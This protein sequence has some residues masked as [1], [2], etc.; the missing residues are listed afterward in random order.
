MAKDTRWTNDEWRLLQ[1][2]L[3]AV[4]GTTR[5]RL[6]ELTQVQWDQVVADTKRSRAD[7]DAALDTMLKRQE[8][9]G[10]RVPVQT[11]ERLFRESVP[12]LR[13]CLQA[14]LKRKVVNR[15]SQTNML[16]LVFSLIQFWRDRFAKRHILRYCRTKNCRGLRRCCPRSNPFRLLRYPTRTYSWYGMQSDAQ[17]VY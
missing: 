8:L 4:T 3:F 10:G 13:A 5:I 11:T 15:F 1:T 16:A 9:P 7:I 2:S 12:R 6:S 17:K 14:M